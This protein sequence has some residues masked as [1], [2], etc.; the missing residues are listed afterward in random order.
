MPKSC[1]S[2]EISKL[3][4]GAAEIGF[5]VL[6]VLQRRGV[7]KPPRWSHRTSAAVGLA[8]PNSRPAPPIAGHQA[9]TPP[10]ATISPP[11]SFVRG[12]EME[13][14]RMRRAEIL[15]A[16]LQICASPVSLVGPSGRCG[17]GPGD[18]SDSQRCSGDLRTCSERLEIVLGPKSA[19]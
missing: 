4:G 8:A 10:V 2:V 18:T 1:Y 5:R 7:G 16:F 17:T 15:R 12:R 11:P 13:G 6:T 3:K 9:H 14:L 19:L